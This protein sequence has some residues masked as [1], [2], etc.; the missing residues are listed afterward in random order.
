MK[1]KN[2]IQFNCQHLNAAWIK[3]TNVLFIIAS[4]LLIFYSASIQAQDQ[5]NSADRL[6][7]RNTKSFLSN[8]R[9]NEQTTGA[10]YSNA[11]RIENLLTKVQPSVYFYSGNAKTYGEKPVCL[12]TNVQSLSSIGDSSL[13]RNNIEMAKITIETT[14]DLNGT[15]DLNVFADFKNLKYIQI[16]S[17]VPTTEQAI[18]NMIRYNGEK[19]SVFYKIQTGDSEQ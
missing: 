14:S 18:N 7:V 8:L 3:K 6:Q 13:S 1:T 2:E 12:F 5:R 19:Y 11:Q 17:K 15:I 10:A 16:L 9:T 4:L